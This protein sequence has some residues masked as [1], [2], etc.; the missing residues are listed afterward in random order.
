VPVLKQLFSH[1]LP[2]PSPRQGGAK[3]GGAVPLKQ[4]NTIYFIKSFPPSP[5]IF[6]SVPDL[7]P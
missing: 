3:R 6:S 7:N 1:G 5:I 4:I 2:R